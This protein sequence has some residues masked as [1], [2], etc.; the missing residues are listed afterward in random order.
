MWESLPL[1]HTQSRDLV[2]DSSSQFSPQHTGRTS[3]LLL[4]TQIT[5]FG[6]VS[7][8]VT[9]S[10]SEEWEEGRRMRQLGLY[11]YLSVVSLLQLGTFCFRWCIPG[12][13]FFHWITQ[14]WL[15]HNLGL[16][17][18][19][20]FSVPTADVSLKAGRDYWYY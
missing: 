4:L 5:P 17:P 16:L 8:L 9:F 11:A 7:T 2:E 18:R 3:K 10:S 19:S 6:T 1:I 13:W 12:V 14:D 20:L 15:V